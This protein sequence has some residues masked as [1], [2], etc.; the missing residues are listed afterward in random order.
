MWYWLPWLTLDIPMHDNLP[1]RAAELAHL[2]DL[3]RTSLSLAD[4]ANPLLNR[5]SHSRAP[6]QW[7]RGFAATEGRKT[8]R[9]G[10]HRWP[11]QWGRGFAATEGPTRST[12]H[13]LRW[14]LQ[15]GRGF[16][17]TEGSN[18]RHRCRDPGDA[19][20]GPWLRS[21]G[22][23]ERRRPPPFRPVASMGPWLRSHG[24][25]SFPLSVVVA[26]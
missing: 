17:A 11:L 15:W 12:L 26:S 25:Y 1:E 7:G 20:M 22:R 3:I 2:T 6:L 21:H 13:C 23:I 16:A 10:W 5:R 9:P 4:A 18:A 8:P 14:W 24:R 19:S